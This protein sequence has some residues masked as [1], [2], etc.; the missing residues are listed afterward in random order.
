MKKINQYITGLLVTSLLFSCKPG[1]K[2]REVSSGSAD[3]SRYVAVG[4]S[5]TSG[6]QDNALYQDGQI[7]SYPALLARQ[8][9]LA[10]GGDFTIPYMP[11]G[12]G[13]DGSGNPRLVLAFTIPC[14]STT[15]GVSPIFDPNGFSELSNVSAQGPYNLVGVPGA[16]AVD[17]NFPLYSSS[18]GNPFLGRFCQTPGTSTMIS[19]ALRSKPTFFSFWLG[20]NDVLLYALGGAVTSTNPLSPARI[21]DTAAVRTNIQIAIDSLTSNGAKGVMANVPDITSIPYFT[22][23][24][25][26]G[27]VLTQDQATQLNAIFS[28]SPITWNK[29]A[30]GFLI[31]DSASPGFF[32]HATSHDLI[33]LSTPQDSLSCAGWGTVKPLTDAYVLDSAEVAEI[34]TTIKQYNTIIKTIATQKNLAHVDIY[35]YLKTFTSGIIYNGISMNAKYVSGGAFS[36]D[37]VH[38]NQRGYA[39]IANEFID[40]I[41]AK[42]GSTIPHVD[43]TRYQGILL[44]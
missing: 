3:F 18:F 36:L 1:L 2:E 39:L 25:Y 28:G 21:S 38:P 22:T 14:N 40:V 34:Q 42:Y 8:F 41:N 32:R 16:R 12:G 37:G 27:A 35:T 7:N 33:L 11:A 4:N 15:P 13:N 26:N 9:Q 17:C 44:P 23:I 5:L 30:N 43:P 20:S 24:P 10:G 31:V 19:E 29:G 6:Y